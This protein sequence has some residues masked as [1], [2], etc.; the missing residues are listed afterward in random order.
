[1]GKCEN[2]ERFGRPGAVK[3]L[4]QYHFYMGNAVFQ[5]GIGALDKAEALIE[6]FEI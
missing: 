5:V 6:F 2:D 4:F 1:M 3:V